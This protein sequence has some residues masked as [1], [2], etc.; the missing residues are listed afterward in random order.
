MDDSIRRNLI[1]KFGTR[2]KRQR[3]NHQQN[4]SRIPCSSSTSTP[5]ITLWEDFLPDSHNFRQY[6]I[7]E[8]STSEGFDSDI[9]L[10]ESID[11]R[12]YQKC[13]IPI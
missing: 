12:Q 4:Q 1:K 3:V 11:Y 6:Y 5:N 10:V 2:F 13:W 9:G 8:S 7:I